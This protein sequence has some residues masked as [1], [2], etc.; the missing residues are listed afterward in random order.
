[1]L[2]TPHIRVGGRAGSFESVY[3]L[4]G[5]ES[6]RLDTASWSHTVAPDS[7]TCQPVLR[8]ADASGSVFAECTP[9]VFFANNTPNPFGFTYAGPAALTDDFAIQP[10]NGY[11]GYLFHD[12]GAAPIQSAMTVTWPQP[13]GLAAAA[14]ATWFRSPGAI[15][16]GPVIGSGIAVESSTITVTLTAPVAAGQYLI[17]ACSLLDTSR[18]AFTA[19]KSA[20]TVTDSVGGNVLVFDA[21]LTVGLGI[22]SV[23][24]ATGLAIEGVYE[25]YRI[26]NP[27][28]VGATVTVTFADPTIEWFGCNLHAVT[29]MAAA[30]PIGP[31]PGSGDVGVGAGSATSPITFPNV[32]GPPD[33]I[34]VGG[35]LIDGAYVTASNQTVDVMLERGGVTQ[36]QT[37]ITASLPTHGYTQAALPDLHLGPGDTLTALAVNSLG[38]ARVADVVTDFLLWGVDD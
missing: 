35:V 9:P 14:A 17:I 7:D 23:R 28:G 12:F 33:P 37:N 22:T 16:M 25:L 32:V 5:A 34:W 15:S 18:F 4:G 27:L 13:P 20:V 1:M 38:Q 6:F 8:C 29:G 30:N 11:Q 36:T 26:V 19:G 2:T 31:N 3:T 21:I 24:A 10:P